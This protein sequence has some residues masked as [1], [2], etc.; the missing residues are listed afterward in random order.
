MTTLLHTWHSPSGSFSIRQT[1]SGSTAILQTWSLAG[2]LLFLF[3]KLK[4]CLKECQFGCV[5][6]IHENML[7][8]LIQ[9]S[10]KSR[11][12][13]SVNWK[14]HWNGRINAGGNYFKADTIYLSS[15]TRDTTCRIRN[16]NVLYTR[17]T[18]G[19]TAD[20]LTWNVRAATC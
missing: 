16:M 13:C 17:Y 20:S 12:E 2:T 15:Y 10:S 1:S 3:P 8:E 11:T 14:H 4:A 19:N 9:I 6:E 5:E 18:R 7:K